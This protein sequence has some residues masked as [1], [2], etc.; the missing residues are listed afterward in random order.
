MQSARF[1]RRFL[2]DECGTTA[3]EYALIGALVAVAIVSS[4]TATGTK[5]AL[6]YGGVSTELTAVA[7]AATAATGDTTTT[8]TKDKKPKK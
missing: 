8:A 4:I 6:L 2:C 5:V 1:T 7:T 3:I